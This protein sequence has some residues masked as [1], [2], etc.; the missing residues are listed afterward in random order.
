[1]LAPRATITVATPIAAPPATVWAVLAATRC[2]AAWNPTIARLDGRWRAGARL[3]N[4]VRGEGRDTTTFRPV[5]IAVQPPSVLRWRGALAGLPPL[6]DAV[7][8]FR[9]EP[10]GRDGTV[11]VQ[12]ERF[13]GAALWLWDA[14]DLVPGFVAAGRALGRR[15]AACGRR[16]DP[17]RCP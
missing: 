16:P 15:V 10:D 9:L 13:R 3:V 1:M 7:H 2:Y 4:V 6:L 14:A 17:C 12:D 11:F 8:A 5:V